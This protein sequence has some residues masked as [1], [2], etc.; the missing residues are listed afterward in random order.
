MDEEIK[1]VEPIKEELKEKISTEP[2]VVD[3]I[4]PIDEKPLT[5]GHSFT[6]TKLPPDVVQK[7]L[8]KKEKI[9]DEK[10]PQPVIHPMNS[11]EYLRRKQKIKEARKQ[12]RKNRKKNKRR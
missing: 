4:K 7:V 1:P 10:K 9:E 5:S 6:E 12:R 11:N 8:E 3:D 2:I